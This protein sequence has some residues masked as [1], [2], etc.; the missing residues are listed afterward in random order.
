[1]KSLQLVQRLNA[2]RLKE[3]T[4]TY[5]EALQTAPLQASEA[6]TKNILTRLASDPCTWARP[7]PA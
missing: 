1:M 3:A 5:L 7:P 4:N 2:R 6:R